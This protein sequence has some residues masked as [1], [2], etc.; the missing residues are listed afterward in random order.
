MWGLGL[1]ADASARVVISYTMPVETVPGV[2]AA[3]YPA[4]F[5]VIQLVT[6]TYYNLA[7][8]YRLLGARWATHSESAG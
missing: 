6:N 4:T 2:G 8:L 5:I 3:L 1:L 7:G